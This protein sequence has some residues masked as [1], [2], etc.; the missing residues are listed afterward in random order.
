MIAVS[1]P[2][3][4]RDTGN[5]DDPVRA[6][7]D[8]TSQSDPSTDT[9]D[10]ASLAANARAMLNAQANKASDQGTELV[11][12]Q[13]RKVGLQA[14]FSGFDNQSLAVVALNQTAMFSTEE[15]RAAKKEGTRPAQP[16]RHSQ[17]F[18]HDAEKR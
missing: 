9:T 18:Q 13:G 7:L 1:A 8:A 6:L 10:P 2:L 14:D 12:D 4:I 17:R 16:N 11:F 3:T 5:A 15:S